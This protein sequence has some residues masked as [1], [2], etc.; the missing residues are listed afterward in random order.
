MLGSKVQ[1]NG[2]PL[3]PLR[4]CQILLLNPQLKLCQQGDAGDS[5]IAI[6]TLYHLFDLSLLF[7]LV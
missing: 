2:L 7:V 1:P 4:A 5:D 6:N 3:L